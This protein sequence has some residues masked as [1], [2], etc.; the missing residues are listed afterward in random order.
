MQKILQVMTGV[1][2]TTVS[3]TYTHRCLLSKEKIQR[4]GAVVHGADFFYRLG[5]SDCARRDSD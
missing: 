5:G 2:F 3:V 1:L 4:A